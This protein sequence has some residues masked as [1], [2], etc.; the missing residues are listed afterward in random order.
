MGMPFMSCHA[1]P[2]GL[3]MDAV[4]MFTLEQRMT[5]AVKDISKRT[6]AVA[7]AR[8]IKEFSSDQRKGLLARYASPLIRAGESATAAE[9]HARADAAYQRELD[10]LAAQYVKAEKHIAG[11]DAAH[12]QY[13]AARSALSLA[14]E[15]VKM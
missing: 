12:C 4:E 14:R 1:T 9:L 7:M 6:D 5:D 8:Q 2:K 10:E 15:L 13:E 3:I 11:F